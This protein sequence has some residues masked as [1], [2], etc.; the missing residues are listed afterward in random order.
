M[1]VHEGNKITSLKTIA[2]ISN[3]YFV[4]KIIKLRN[5]FTAPTMSAINIL[6]C[7]FPRN[8]NKQDLQQIIVDQTF[9][10]IKLYKW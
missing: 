10:I 2:N 1:L 4:D 5:E 7:I 6:N 8:T 9:D 3:K